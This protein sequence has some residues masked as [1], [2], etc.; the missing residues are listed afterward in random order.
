MNR[1]IASKEIMELFIR[2]VNKYNSLEKIPVKYGKK[3]NLYHSERHM[4]DKIGYHPGMNVTEFARTVGVTKG[5]ISQMVK[6]LENKGVVRRYKNSS[7]DKEIFIELTK[8]GKDFYKK[9]QDINE[10]TIRPLY[11]E[12]K[13]HPAE[14][15]EFLLT[16]FKWFDEFLDMSSKKMKKHLKNGC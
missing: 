14:K 2:V 15:V 3:H 8:T 9:H 7:N 1:K 12:L 4:L 16:M 11:E 5:A 10:E 6:K 13:K